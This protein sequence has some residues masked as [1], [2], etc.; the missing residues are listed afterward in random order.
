L[1]YLSLPALSEG[2]I[3]PA[4]FMHD[5]ATLEVKS[6]HTQARFMTLMQRVVELLSG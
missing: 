1:L 2:E 3:T 5:H 6:P 4:A